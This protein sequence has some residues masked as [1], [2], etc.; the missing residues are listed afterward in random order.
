MPPDPSI[1]LVLGNN[2]ALRE[3]AP[4]PDASS[5]LSNDAARGFALIVGGRLTGQAFQFAA[6]IV[7]ARLLVPS[8]YGL[9][10]I[11]WTFTGFANLFNDL[12]LTAGLVQLARMTER[13]ASTAF[14]INGLLGVLLTAITFF[15]RHPFAELF[16]QPRLAPLLAVSSLTFLLSITPVPFAVLERQMR[17]G[18]AAAIDIG[19]TVTGLMVSVGCAVEGVGAM[20]LVIGPLTATVIASIAGLACARWVPKVWPSRNSARML[21]KFGGHLTGYTFVGFW[22]RNADNLLLGRFAGPL[23][24]GL[25]N[26]AYQ[27]MLLPLNQ[28]GSVLGRVLLP[29]FSS[30]Q[31][32]LPRLRV[33]MVRVLR[34]TATFVFPTLLGLAAVA[35]DFVLTAYGER[36]H[37]A[38][39][40]IVI[41]AISAM[42]AVFGIASAQVA[43][44][45]GNPRLLST[46]GILYGLSAIGAIVAGLPW[47]AEGVAIGLAVRGILMA[48]L[49]MIPAK[50]SIG[51]GIRS[52]IQATVRPFLAATL[53]AI[54]VA[55]LG[56]VLDGPLPIGLALL[57]QLIVAPVLYVGLILSIDRSALS[58]ALIL[59]RRRQVAEPSTDENATEISLSPTTIIGLDDVASSPHGGSDQA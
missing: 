32:D 44:A 18:T 13:D 2:R 7:L 19:S 42:P 58:D 5:S 51:I 23:Q 4:R 28:V 48:P 14:T 36:W 35:H 39:V 46:W 20:S 52:L 11:V 8:A 31:D 1:D 41:L 40:L 53:M 57:A 27:L 45:T 26:R 43:V 30:M 6:S 33:A 47:K 50:R 56:R 24:L 49:E 37:G 34:G 16:G 25:Y 59:V 17:F 15:L 38:I 21:M 54:V 9:V 22:G 29:L 10:A 55:A 12:G 3:V